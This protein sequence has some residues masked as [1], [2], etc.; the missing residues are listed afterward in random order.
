MKFHTD[1]RQTALQVAA[2]RGHT[3]VVAALVK[4]KSPLEH[5]DEDGDTALSYAVLGCATSLFQST[6]VIYI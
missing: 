5:Q 1:E 3:D 4:A 2:H 6:R